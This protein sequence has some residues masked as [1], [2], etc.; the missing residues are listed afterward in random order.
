MAFILGTQMDRNWKMM[1]K[2]SPTGIRRAD[3]LL[4]S[5]CQVFLAADQL[6]IPAVQQNAFQLINVS[7]LLAIHCLLQGSPDW[8]IHRIN[9][10]TVRWPVFW[11][12]ELWYMGRQVSNGV[13]WAV[14][15]G[16]CFSTENCVTM[17]S[18]RLPRIFN[19]FT[20]RNLADP[21]AYCE[22]QKIPPC[23]IW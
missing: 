20:S 5:P 1:S 23:D 16:H 18:P 22:A 3:P 14:C 21:T 17:T 10:W 2:I 7:Y 13:A 8:V 15:R 19:Q 12:D 6:L 4:W 9:I 11:F